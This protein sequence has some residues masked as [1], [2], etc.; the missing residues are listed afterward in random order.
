[1]ENVQ[2][3]VVCVDL[4]GVLNTYDGWRGPEFF[5][6]V[7]PGAADFLRQLNAAGFAVV[8]FTVRYNP[9]VE[10]W[11]AEHGLA[12]LVSAVTDRKPPAHV[13]LDDRAVCF[14]G[15]FHQALGEILTFRAHWE[16]DALV[17]EHAHLPKQPPA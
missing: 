3:P 4:D 12:P 11:L 16:A 6:G 7:R 5:H 8:I 17:S 1:M 10:T 9:W 2:K 14:T 13:Y 15:D